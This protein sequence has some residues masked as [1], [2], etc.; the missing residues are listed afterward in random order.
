LVNY[1]DLSEKSNKRITSQSK[2]INGAALQRP[3][4]NLSVWVSNISK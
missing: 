3:L 4:Q 2:R 1:E